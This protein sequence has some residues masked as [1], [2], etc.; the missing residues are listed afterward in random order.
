MADPIIDGGPAFPVAWPAPNAP[1]TGMSLR[2]W[3]AANAPQMPDQWWSDT[4]AQYGGRTGSYAEAIAAWR[5]FYADAML[6]ARE[7]RS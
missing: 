2:D 5:Y 7:D 1:E 3:F 6:K 4:K